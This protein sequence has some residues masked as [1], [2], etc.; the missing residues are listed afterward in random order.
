MK[1]AGGLLTTILTVVSAAVIGVGV[2]VGWL[3][4]GSQLQ[5][6]SGATS[7]DF[8]V[9]ALI[10]TG[11]IVTYVFVLFLA[12]WVMSLLGVSSEVSAP[13]GARAPWMRGMTE[14]AGKGDGMNGVE[15][16]F[17]LTTLLV[18]AAVFVWFLFFAEGGGLP[19]P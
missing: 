14:G 17:V 5:G 18:T 10:M 12:G 8:S 15:R 19:R 1:A 13:R 2:P 4:I 6:D 9:A 7:L 3:W 11:I 16:T